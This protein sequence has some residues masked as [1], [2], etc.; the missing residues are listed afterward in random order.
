[1]NTTPTTSRIQ[2]HSRITAAL[3]LAAAV[4]FGGAMSAGAVVPQEP[5]AQ[6]IAQAK[7]PSSAIQAYAAASAAEP[8]SLNVEEVYL[9]RMV[10]FGLP[11]MADTQAADLT[12]RAPQEGLPWAI[13]AYMDAK[14]DQP[15]KAVQEIQT[16]VNAAPDDPFVLR[17]AGQMMAWYDFRADK[18]LLTVDT[19]RAF[20]DLRGTV[21]GKVAFADA[22]SAASTQF[23]QMTAA[24]AAQPVPQAA[25][26]VQ[27]AAPTLPAVS[28]PVE[29]PTYQ[30][31]DYTV[32]PYYNPDL[33]V[34]PY[35]DWDNSP[36]WPTY[37][38]IAIGN[39]FGRG[40]DGDHDRDDRG[41]RGGF[42]GSTGGRMEFRPAPSF[43]PPMRSFSP[44]PAPAFA[45]SIGAP[46]LSNPGFSGG[47][48]S[49]A[50]RGGTMGGPSVG[51]GGSRGGGGGG[52][53]R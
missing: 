37:G 30:Y 52:G 45:P 12:K 43:S 46:R 6:A 9:Q 15:A 29:I 8:G 18:L 50:M 19:Q 17:T 31:P 1:M 20:M 32:N 4:C 10:D 25:P 26:Q 2:L 51:G 27:W 49:G 35:P 22:Y 48:N 24:A 34:S 13:A 3:A 39:D 42:S 33:Y 53:R 16:A 23:Q 36:W 44:P 38:F 11:E 40:R 14:R 28:P 5:L 47:T 41:S 7:D 21:N